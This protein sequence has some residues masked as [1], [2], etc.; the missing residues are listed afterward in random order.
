MHDHTY[1]MAVAWQNT[2]YNQPPHLGFYLPDF[3]GA[4][5]PTGI[6]DAVRLN[7]KGQMINDN[8]YMLDGRRVEG[9][10]KAKGIYLR[11]GKKLIIK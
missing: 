6:S 5:N 1:R 9:E 2:A 11:N 10:P 3:I 4:Y 8:W 7:D